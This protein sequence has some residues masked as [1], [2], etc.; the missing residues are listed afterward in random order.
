MRQ[1]NRLFRESSRVAS[2]GAVPDF[3]DRLIAR[4]ESAYEELVRVHGPRMLTVA[5]RYLPCL[6]DA[7]DA[8]QEAFVNVVRSVAAFQR[9]SSIETWLHRI[10]VNCALM[11]LRRRRRKPEA[12][13]DESTVEEGTSARWRCWPPSSAHEVVAAQEMKRLVHLCVNRLP[14]A[15]R[16]VVLLRDVDALPLAEIANLLDVGVSTVKTRLHRARHAL[17]RALGPQL[18]DVDA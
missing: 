9:A 14:E 5:S 4:D 8:L 3:I 15:Q 6:A 13:L 18:L 12:V 2:I 10:V 17:Q 16:S 7:E 1:V 11:T